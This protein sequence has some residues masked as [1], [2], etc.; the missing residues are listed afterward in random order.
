MLFRFFYFIQIAY[1]SQFELCTEAKRRLNR[2]PPFSQR[3]LRRKKHKKKPPE[4]SDGFVY[5]LNYLSRIAAW[6]A[7]RR[8]I[9]T[10]KGEQLT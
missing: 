1:A 8:A 6:A 7:A 5:P 9:G 3:R 4:N 2:E 10:R